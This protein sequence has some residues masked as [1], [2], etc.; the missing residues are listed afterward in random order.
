MMKRAGTKCQIR[1]TRCVKSDEGP[2]NRSGD[3]IALAGLAT[4]GR[5]EVA[6]YATFRLTKSARL[7][8]RGRV[9]RIAVKPLRY[10]R[11][12][13]QAYAIMAKVLAR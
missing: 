3:A 1:T 4:F 10:D 12:D 11:T 6:R 8:W 2:W 7:P 5:E 13:E 9:R